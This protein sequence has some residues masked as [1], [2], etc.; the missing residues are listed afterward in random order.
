M[1]RYT[2][3]CWGTMKNGKLEHG[4]Y[5]RGDNCANA[6]LVQHTAKPATAEA[7]AVVMVEMEEDEKGQLTLAAETILS[8]TEA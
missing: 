2:H 1:K 6:E 5:T 4:M 7:Y 8:I 3:Y